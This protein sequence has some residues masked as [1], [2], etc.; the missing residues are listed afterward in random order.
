MRWLLPS[1]CTRSDGSF[2]ADWCVYI[3][4]LLLLDAAAAIGALGLSY[5]LRF[6]TGRRAFNP[7]L[8]TLSDYLVLAAI[9]L[10]AWLIATRALGLYERESLLA[11]TG[12]YARVIQASAYLLVGVV[13]V[14]FVA[15]SNVVSRG[16]LLL[17]WVSLGVMGGLG[18]FLARRAAYYARRWGAF[19]ARVIMVGADDRA[20]QLADY[21]SRTEYEVLGFL[22]DFRAVGSAVGEKRWRVLGVASQLTRAEELGAD[23]VIIVP[24]A[25]SWESRRASM[26]LP[27]RR[28]FDVR[29]LASPEDAL[30][31]GVRVTH[32]AGVPVYAF[33]QVRLVGVEAA[34]KRAFDITVALALLVIVGPF[35]ALR[36]AGRAVRRQPLFERH[37]LLGSN[38]DAT[39]VY[40]L[41]GNGDRVLSKSP[42]LVNVLRGQMSIVGP[43]PVEE[44]QEAH[45]PELRLMKPGLTSV[46]RA[47]Q[48]HLDRGS[49]ISIELDYVRN[50]SIWRDLQVVW[51]RVMSAR[52]GGHGR[53]V[54]GG[55][56]WALPSYAVEQPQR[57][58]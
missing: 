10:V 9:V 41:A 49:T 45:S 55:A 21:L 47:D 46:V 19:R 33:E 52:P 38:G 42:A 23:E 50:Y 1:N 31:A 28:R 54:E 17:F 4:V 30:T 6:G 35:A 48:R 56:L 3:L 43:P 8:V 29:I 11:G 13:L 14:D 51:H 40:A 2:R 22:D 26:E 24:S 5:Y 57:E 53:A 16:W 12:E 37:R 34:V 32:R 25:I 18:R 39:T 44:G 15:Q 36:L 27:A 7:S 58:S 20:V